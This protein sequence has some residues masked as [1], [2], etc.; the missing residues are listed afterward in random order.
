MAGEPAPRMNRACGHT[1][2]RP[3]CIRIGSGIGCVNLLE[4][5]G[6]TDNGAME[7][8]A[9]RAPGFLAWE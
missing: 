9:T 7:A 2:S 3:S 5:R 1:P 4:P 6:R 8:T